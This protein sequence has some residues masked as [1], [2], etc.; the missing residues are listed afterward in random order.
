MIYETPNI[1]ERRIEYYCTKEGRAPFREWFKSLKNEE[2]Q[3][4]IDSR[5]GR[6][7]VGNFGSCESV[8]SGV[9]ELKIHYG[10]GYRL[11]FGHISNKIVLVLCAGDKSSQHKD[12]EKARAYWDDYKRRN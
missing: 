2:I 12:I 11:Y 1:Y 5:I 9:F 8:G 3:E 10:P 6:L 7:R 4:L